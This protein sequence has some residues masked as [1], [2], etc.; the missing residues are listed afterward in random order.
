[1]S[2]E[3]RGA[4]TILLLATGLVLTTCGGG[5]DAVEAPAAPTPSSDAAPWPAPSDPLERIAEAGLEPATH[6]FLNVHRHAHLDVFVNGEA[7]TVPAGIGIDITDPGV[8][9]LETPAGEGYGGIEE[10]DEPCISP[11]HTHDTTGVLHTEAGEAT[12]HTLGQFFVEWGVRL[13]GD[14]V[15]GYCAPQATIQVFVDGERHEGDP[16]AIELADG[17]EIAIVIGSL[18]EE[19]P[20]TYDFG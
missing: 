8:K 10:C 3:P 4:R 19:V 18:P 15:G 1:M 5:V 7:V 17:Q 6:E 14:C 13:D 12:T 16:T 9:V 2:L 20:T 11:L